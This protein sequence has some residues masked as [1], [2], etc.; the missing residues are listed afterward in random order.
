MEIGRRLKQARLEAGLTQRQLCGDTI[1]R[2]MLSQIE[3]GS[4]KPS[5]A[6]LQAL[7]GRLQK[8]VSFFL[9]EDAVYLPNRHILEEARK[10]YASGDP[11]GAAEA[12]EAYQA[13]DPVLDAE[14][15][16]LAALVAMAQA[17]HAMKQGK[18][19]YAAQLLQDAA[20]EGKA[21]P[22]YSAELESRR[23]LLLAKT[24][25]EKPSILAKQ[26]PQMDEALLLLARGALETG[27]F[28]RCGKLL[29]AAQNQD[30][31]LWYYLRGQAYCGEKA[32]GEA[33][34]MLTKAERVYPEPTAPLLEIC[35]REQ[36][37]FESAYRYAC[38]QKAR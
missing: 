2:N 17:E 19:P 14:K 28:A 15:H 13:P 8:P 26:L 38:L 24:G 22:Y 30:A 31:P 32:Y 7:A 34:A 4:A 16:L 37:D 35:Y 29:D 1:T 10:R 21:T 36:G 18:N 12:L 3:N 11:E 27:D 6:T 5:M 9:E 33:I 23:I 25:R 20:E